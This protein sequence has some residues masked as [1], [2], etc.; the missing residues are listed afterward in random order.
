M[1]ER[2]SSRGGGDRDRGGDRDD[3]GGR[4]ND[5]G[6]SRRSRDDD[7]G[8]DRDRGRSSRGG[9]G[10]G[11]SYRART[12]ESARAR[13]EKGSK[14]FDTYLRDDIKMFKPNDGPNTIRIL[15]P[16]FDDADSFGIDAWVHFNVGPDSQSYLCLEKMKGEA[17]PVCEE[18]ARAKKDREDEDY[19]KDLEPTR[20]V[21]FYLIDR[22]HERDGL[23]A[24]AAP[25]SIE[26][27]IM[28]L[29]VDR[30][31]GEVIPL[32]DPD[33]GY[34]IEFDKRGKGIGTKY[35]GIQ[36]ARRESALGDRRA[37][38]FAIDNPLPSI[39]E[40]YSYDHIDRVLG[41]GGGHSTRSDRDSRDD[42][43]DGG[44]NRGEPARDED[45]GADRSER[46]R[47][48]SDTPR[49]TWESVHEMTADELD[50]LVESEKLDINPNKADSDTQLADWI[51]EDLKLTKAEGRSRGGGDDKDDTMST[52]DRLRNMR[53]ERSR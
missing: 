52:S 5:R 38:Q 24:W 22:D 45:R 1:V 7:R 11:F 31:T 50:A 35:E 10:S 47:S 29:S 53:N 28:R 16:T 19:I 46:G 42:R 25:Q 8:G 32:D 33:A 4:D 21:L 23:Q 17:C 34:D 20:R 41:G 3:R 37:L 30:K 48:R 6:D 15:P 18:L 40:Y 27:N 49:Y 39:L 43:G 12:A 13:A 14:N 26:S 44:R 9:S 36:I 51:C 2:S